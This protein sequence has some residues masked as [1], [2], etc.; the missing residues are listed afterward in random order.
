MKFQQSLQTVELVNMTG[1]SELLGVTLDTAY[2]IRT[3]NDYFPLCQK[4]RGASKFYNADQIRRFAR[5]L[6]VNVKTHDTILNLK[7]GSLSHLSEGGI[8]DFLKRHCID[9]KKLKGSYH[10]DKNQIQN[11]LNDLKNEKTMVTRLYSKGKLN[12]VQ[13]AQRLS[14][15]IQRVRTILSERVIKVVTVNNQITY[16]YSDHNKIITKNFDTVLDAI[17]QAKK[18]IRTTRYLPI[19]IYKG[20][21]KTHNAKQIFKVAF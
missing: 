13:I 7:K 11:V 6:D 16:Q 19:S 18:H 5:K 9:R 21:T 2:K 17:K 14:I 8:Y 12:R 15:P 4:K 10:Y 3:R 20:D 1:V